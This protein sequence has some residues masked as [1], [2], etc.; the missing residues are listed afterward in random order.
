MAPSSPV[1]VWVCKKGAVSRVSGDGH[2]AS[3]AGA[4]EEGGSG[5]YSLD[6][7]NNRMLGLGRLRRRRHTTE[8]LTASLLHK[9]NKQRETPRGWRG[10]PELSTTQGTR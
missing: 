6:P 5:T 4:Q 2:L 3:H 9:N 10:R 8:L 7:T 1:A